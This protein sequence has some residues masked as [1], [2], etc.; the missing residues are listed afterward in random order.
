[1]RFL[2][3]ILSHSIFIA[4]CAMGLCYQTSLVLHTQNSLSLYGFIFFSTICSYN[5]YWLLSKFYFTKN[6]MN[7]GFIKEQLSFVV[8]FFTAL[9]GTVYSVIKLPFIIPYVSLGAFFS[10]I[11]LLCRKK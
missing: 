8:L 4:L 1:M 6:G 10:K 9:V 11:S 3:F 7:W 2:H 5:F